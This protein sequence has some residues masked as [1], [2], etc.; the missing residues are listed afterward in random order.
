M[1]LQQGNSGRPRWR[2]RVAELWTFLIEV[3]QELNKI[4]WP[5]WKEIR[6]T[7]VIVLLVVVAI[8]AYVFGVDAL[9]DY[10]EH[11]ILRRR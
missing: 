2:L 6:T 11:V 8:S 4:T 3:R 5:G 9:C 1:S 10:F 7:T